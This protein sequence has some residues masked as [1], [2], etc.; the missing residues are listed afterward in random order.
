MNV[1]GLVSKSH[2]NHSRHREGRDS[3]LVLVVLQFGSMTAARFEMTNKL[4]T[5]P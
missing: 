2:D 1:I 3:K 5:A 4:R